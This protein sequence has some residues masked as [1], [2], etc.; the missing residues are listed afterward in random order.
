VSVEASQSE[1]FSRY[2]MVT[3]GLVLATLAFVAL[4]GASDPLTDAAVLRNHYDLLVTRLARLDDLHATG[5]ISNDAH[6]AARESLMTKLGVIAIQL[7]AHGG[8]V[9][10]AKLKPEAAA[11]AVKPTQAS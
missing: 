6:K 9:P 7:R 1:S 8:K 4:R 5:S 2:L 10:E 11:H 3:L